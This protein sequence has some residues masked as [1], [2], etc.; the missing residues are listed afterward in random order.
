MMSFGL[1]K[2]I[3]CSV[4]RTEKIAG[5]QS[6]G[7]FLDKTTRNLR[8]DE[9][10]SKERK[11]LRRVQGFVEVLFVSERKT[12]KRIKLKRDRYRKSRGGYARF[13][14]IRCAKCRFPVAIYQKDGSGILKRMYID[15]IFDQKGCFTGE[16]FVCGK[17]RE[18]LGVRT[19]YK[20]EKRPAVCLFEA[21]VMKELFKP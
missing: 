11:I 17:C 20:K 8:G 19:I 16:I 2:R 9:K 6:E 10:G 18:V 14:K 13:L 3:T 5:R 4:R 21:S 1:M 12:M 7:H 15:R